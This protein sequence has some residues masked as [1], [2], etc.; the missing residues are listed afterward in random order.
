LAV[1]L[2]D[3]NKTPTLV[4]RTFK[5]SSATNAVYVNLGGSSNT[6]VFTALSTLSNFTVP[7]SSQTITFSST[8]MIL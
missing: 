5:D 4:Y 6:T 2:K 7:L 3:Q 1:L 8:A